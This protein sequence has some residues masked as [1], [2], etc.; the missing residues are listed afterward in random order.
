MY[1]ISIY[2]SS[3]RELLTILCYILFII[4]I[5]T[6]NAWCTTYV[7]TIVGVAEQF[8]NIYASLSAVVAKEICFLK[9]IVAMFF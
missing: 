4:I 6:V 9:Y 3:T 7:H 8:Y 5:I 2:R 1:I